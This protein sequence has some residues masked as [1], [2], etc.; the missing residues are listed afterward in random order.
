M[1]T[2]VRTLGKV[3]QTLFNNNFDQIVDEYKQKAIK[4]GYNGELLFKKE[5][6]NIIILVSIEDK[7][8]NK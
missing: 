8:I 2:L 4:L 6:N 7:K 5:H 1:E 3:K